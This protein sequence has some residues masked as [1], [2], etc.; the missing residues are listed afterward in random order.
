MRG[1][2]IAIR[3]ARPILPI[4]VVVA[5][6]FCTRIDTA[7]AVPAAQTAPGEKLTYHVDWNPPWFLFF[8][9]NM[10]AGEVQVQ[11]ELAEYEGIKA[12]KIT[13]TARSSGALAKL[14]G[15]KIDDH[16][17]FVSDADTFCTFKASRQMRE[18]K[19]KR[20]IEVIYYPEGNRLHI[21]EVD[22]AV[23]P[24]KV[25]KDEYKNNIPSCVRDL[26][27]ALFWVRF[28]DFSLGAKQKSTVGADDKIKEV[29]SVVEKKEFIE[30]P[31]GRFEAW[32]LNTIAVLGGLFKDGGQ[33][34]FWISSDSR[35][36]PVAF[37][38]KTSLGKVTG[39]LEA[40]ELPGK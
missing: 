38:A 31:V 3:L 22:V 18:G 30:T 33:F 23:V 15:F 9:P 20:D 34:R 17:E 13:F 40:M 35:R 26:F 10:E 16:F 39:K 24:H 28:K 27:S 14:A 7:Q 6:V 32:R 21:H 25:L 11:V 37:E 29:E 5:Q 36:L 4:V 19:R 12:N 1:S 8:L 2:Y